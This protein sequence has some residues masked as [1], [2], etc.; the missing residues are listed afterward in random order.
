MLRGSDD[1]TTKRILKT[2]DDGTL[3]MNL[4]NLPTDESGAILM[5][6]TNEGLQGPKGD[7][8]DIGDT[9]PQGPKGDTGDK[10]DAGRAGVLRC[11][12]GQSA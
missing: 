11:R 6:L 2:K 5:K 10:G 1:G 3:I 12:C 7:T 8:G 4:D 9:G